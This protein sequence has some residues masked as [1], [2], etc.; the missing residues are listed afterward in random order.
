MPNMDCRNFLHLK[1]TKKNELENFILENFDTKQ[2]AKLAS[3]I[4]DDTGSLIPLIWIIRTA[5]NHLQKKQ[6]KDI[7]TLF[8]SLNKSP[9]EPKYS[10]TKHDL[11]P[12]QKQDYFQ[13]L[14][15]LDW[16]ATHKDTKLST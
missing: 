8:K 16:P 2:D 3:Y 9:K 4:G 5:N 14:A 13:E 15:E 7:K 6:T 1:D 10:R 12:L 11:P